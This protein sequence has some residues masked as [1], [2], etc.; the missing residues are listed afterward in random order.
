[1]SNSATSLDR[2]HDIVQPA[3]IPW[4]PPAPGWSVLLAVLLLVLAWRGW[5][6]WKRWQ[7]DRYRREALRLLE[8]AGD[9]TAI[10]ELL[11]RTAL[12]IA[13]RQNVA[14]MT[15]QRWVA[16]LQVCYL[17]DMP[18]TVRDLLISGVYGSA[19]AEANELAILRDYA[20]SWISGHRRDLAITSGSD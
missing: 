3:P 9:V 10:A 13:P 19:T 18:E 16:W 6:L 5:R 7:A 1:M 4:W 8:M 17:G 15:G 12:V 20:S 11:R 2:L 14:T